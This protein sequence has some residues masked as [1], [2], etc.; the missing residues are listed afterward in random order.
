VA[1]VIFS[2]K[3]GGSGRH[4]RGDDARPAADRPQRLSADADSAAGTPA[5]GPYDVSQAPDGVQRL[6]LGALQI[7]AIDGVEVRVQADPDGGIQQVVLVHGDSA[8]Q[9]GV[10]AAPRSE[11]IWAEVR[12][13]I[14]ESMSADGVTADEVDGLYGVELRAQ[15][16]TP[17]GPAD[18]RF[19]GVDGPRWMVRALYQGLAAGD[20]SQEG[21]LG[22]CLAGLVVDRGE[23]A[24]PVREALPLRLPK[25]MAE[26][27][28]HDHEHDHDHNH[29]GHDH[30]GHVHEDPSPPDVAVNESTPGINGRRPSSR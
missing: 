20:P 13:E 26:H 21:L 16:N 18:I 24:R 3:R 27:A 14:R 7:P 12:E 23:E 1:T 5:R 19:V 6:D 29:D 11:G 4:A 10:F 9:L 28:Q 8:L 30:H 17:Q 25:E 22:E 2:R 15:V